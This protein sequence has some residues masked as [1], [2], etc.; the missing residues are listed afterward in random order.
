MLKPKLSERA[1]K[2]MMYKG[3]FVKSEYGVSD[4]PLV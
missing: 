4:F 3:I 2:I 1:G